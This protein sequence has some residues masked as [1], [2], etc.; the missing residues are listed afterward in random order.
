MSFE[1]FVQ[2]FEGGEPAGMN[3]KA[4]RALFPVVANASERNRWTVRYDHKNES[5]IYLAPLKSKAAQVHGLTVSR[6]CADIRLWEALLAILKGQAAVLYF[7]GGGPLVADREAC[8][9]MPPDMVEALGRPK[10][11]KTAKEI[12]AAVTT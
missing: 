9:Q 8:R 3:R 6:P 12:L 2:C 5:E 1:V 7:P 10:V 4:L 11:V